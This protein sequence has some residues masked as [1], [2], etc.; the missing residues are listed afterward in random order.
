[1]YCFACVG[2]LYLTILGGEYSR[3]KSCYK[4]IKMKT[5]ARINGIKKRI[6]SL[7]SVGLTLFNIAYNSSVYVRLPFTF[8]LYDV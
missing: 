2:I 5:H 6:K 7:F 8:I 1:M 4:N 3:N